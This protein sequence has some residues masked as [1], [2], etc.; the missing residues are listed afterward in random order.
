MDVFDE[1]KCLR[2]KVNTLEKQIKILLPP[3]M[4]SG[5]VSEKKAIEITGLSRES[6]KKK[7]LNGDLDFRA[8]TDNETDTKGRVVRRGIEYKLHQLQKIKKTIF[9]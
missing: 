7:R 1:L 9:E 2:K 6:L 8:R 5:W 3:D 4:I